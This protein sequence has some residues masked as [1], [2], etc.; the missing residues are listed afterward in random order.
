VIE[1]TTKAQVD[2][3]VMDFADRLILALD[4]RLI[5]DPNWAQYYLHKI[6]SLE[7]LMEDIH[8]QITGTILMHHDWGYKPMRR[9]F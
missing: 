9:K 3:K 2:R 6:K 5:L 1:H 8:Q 4:A 7:N